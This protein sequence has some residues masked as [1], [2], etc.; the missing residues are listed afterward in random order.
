M[1]RDFE[2]RLRED[3]EA[4]SPARPHVPGARAAAVLVPV[5]G[6]PEPS[7]ILTLRTDTVSSHRGQISFPGGSIDPGETPKAAALRE[8]QEE[9]GLDPASV[10]VL[11]ELDTTPTYVSGFVITPVV[12]WL[13]R[14]P[15]LAPN[16]AEVARVIEVPIAALTEEIRAE[17]GFLHEGISYP[18]EAWIF[19]DNVVWGVT[20][21]LL[22]LF[23]VALASADLAAAPAPSASPWPDE[24]ASSA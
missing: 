8:A 6:E 15:V 2:R 11:G 20:A 7:L 22:R 12:G 1:T 5:V 21:R 18:T 14:R 24:P 3:L 9:I 4:R 19:E 23:L 10:R 17:P 13:P 16:A